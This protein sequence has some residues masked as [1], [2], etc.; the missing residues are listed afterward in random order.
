MSKISYFILIIISILFLYSAKLSGNIQSDFTLKASIGENKIPSENSHM[1]LERR[2]ES[3]LENN[4]SSINLRLNMLDD[5][6]SK[7][8]DKEKEEERRRKNRFTKDL[9]HEVVIISSQINL[10]EDIIEL[11]EAIKYS[12]KVRSLNLSNNNI[13]NKVSDILTEAIKAN[14]RITKLVLS[15]NKLGDG[16]AESLSKILVRNKTIAILDLSHNQISESGADSL[17]KALKDNNTLNKLYLSYNQIKE[18][19]AQSIG[20]DLLANNQVIAIEYLDL[21]GNHIGDRGVNH[22]S[23]GIKNNKTITE[24]HLSNNQIKNNG[25]F[26]SLN[27]ALKGE[28]TIKVLNLSNNQIQDEGAKSIGEAVQKNKSITELILSDNQIE[29]EGAQWLSKYLENNRIKILHLTGNK[30]D[31]ILRQN[32]SYQ[33][34]KK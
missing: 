18:D 4:L 17:S 23:K 3:Y 12:T 15:Y 16:F 33:L 29:D 20:E 30:I 9:D 6:S 1:L 7:V 10:A 21:S 14:N 32:I 13:G 8:L 34:K 27:D 25:D 11:A 19:G 2:G 24:L 31:E 5:E 22:I 26:P 28:N